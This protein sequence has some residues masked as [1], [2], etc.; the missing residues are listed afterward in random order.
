MEKREAAVTLEKWLDK[1]AAED[2]TIGDMLEAGYV[3]MDEHTNFSLTDAGTELLK[4]FNPAFY[5]RYFINP[6]IGKSKRTNGPHVIM[7]D[8]HYTWTGGYH[9]RDAPRQAGFQWDKEKKYWWTDD[10][11]MARQ[12]FDFA[13]YDAKVEMGAPKIPEGIGKY[14]EIV[15]EGLQYL[16][17]RCDYAVKLDYMGYSKGDT[18]LG[19]S[20]ATKS[21]LTPEQAALGIPMLSI[22][23]HQLPE[24]IRAVVEPFFE[25]VRA[26]LKG[27]E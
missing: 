4:V 15:L 11:A 1:Q 17:D 26:N 21:E 8:G 27:G 16:A 18:H 7:R 24:H 19:H 12:L 13:D 10:P 6:K 9:T 22:H 3:V 20:L 25:V 14:K 5:K 2:A 23:R